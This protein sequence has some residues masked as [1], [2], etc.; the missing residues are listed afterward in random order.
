MSSGNLDTQQ[1]EI[2]GRHWLIDELVR[3]GLEAAEPVR[4]KG[5]DLLASPPDYAWTQPVQIKTH[6][7]RSI[8]VYPAYT[9]AVSSSF[10][11]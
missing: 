9:A 1:V 2:I 5:V 3:A 10:R 7:D 6:R 8:N 11:C 4:D